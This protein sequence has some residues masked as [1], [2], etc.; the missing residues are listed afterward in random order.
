MQRQHFRQQLS[1][2]CDVG[3]VQIELLLAQHVALI[4]ERSADRC[5]YARFAQRVAAVDPLARRQVEGFTLQQTGV[6]QRGVLQ[7]QFTAGE[8]LSRLLVFK[9][10]ARCGQ[11]ICPLQRPAVENSARVELGVCPRQQPAVEQLWRGERQAFFGDNFAV[12]A[13]I[14]LAR[15]REKQIGGAQFTGVLKRCA[16]QIQRAVAAQRTAV[17]YLCGVQRQRLIALHHAVVLQAICRQLQGVRRHLTVVNQRCARNIQ[18]VICQQT[19]RRLIRQAGVIETQIDAVNFAG[20]SQGI[21]LQPQIS[22]GGDQPLVGE[23]R[24]IERQIANAIQ[25]TAGKVIQR[26]GVQVELGIRLQQT[27]VGDALP[28]EGQAVGHQRSAGRDESR[29]GKS[30]IF[31]FRDAAVGDALSVQR[32]TVRREF[33][34]AGNPFG[35]AKR[36]R[37]RC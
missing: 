9:P 5:R 18:L 31:G 36:Q 1:L 8:Q 6:G 32:N 21:A 13:V 14:H 22:I 17:V 4:R 26:I 29:G 34:A 24:Q 35:G 3:G 16:A 15:Q 20:V 27:A 30:D 23:F 28:V 25:R 10:F 12:S 37:F 7:M 33:A 19:T 11:R 2:V